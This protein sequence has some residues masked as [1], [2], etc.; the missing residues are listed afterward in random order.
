MLALPGHEAALLALS[1]DSGL[2]AAASC[3][4]VHIYS[5][6][7]LMAGATAPLAERQLPGTVVQLAWRSGPAA[8]KFAALLADGSLLLARLASSD[9]GAAALAPA[10]PGQIS[11][12]AW[13]PDGSRLAVGAADQVL[14]YAAPGGGS[15]SWRQTAAVRVRSLE[16]QEE[17]GM[18][19]EVDSLYWVAPSTML[20]SSKLLASDGAEEPF[21]P[22]CT[23]SWRAGT[24]DPTADTL[25]LAGAHLLGSL[26]VQMT[27]RCLS[28]AATAAVQ[29]CWRL[30][31]TAPTKALAA[32]CP[33]AQSSLPATLTRVR[34]RRAPGCRPP[35]SHRCEARPM[36]CVCALH[37]WLRPAPRQASARCR[38]HAMQ[39]FARPSALMTIRVGASARLR[40]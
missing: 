33:A 24:A 12:L 2:L 34:R 11:C 39:L 30:S 18:R 31:S 32:C 9:V 38:G 23:L 22:L 14:V 16:I 10:P 17:E 21:A 3:N 5:T 15:D 29:L 20:V 40:Q 26:W 35:H 4:V 13:S 27:Y 37:P 19:L 25:E 8:S 1:S 6:Q 36:S 7:Q 28:R